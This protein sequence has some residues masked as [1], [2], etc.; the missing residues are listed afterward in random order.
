MRIIYKKKNKTK[1]L[2]TNAWDSDPYDNNI[3]NIVGRS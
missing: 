3:N 1:G 2:T